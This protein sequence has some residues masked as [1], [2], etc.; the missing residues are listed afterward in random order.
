VLL[1]AVREHQL[2]RLRLDQLRRDL[3]TIDKA[4]SMTPG[5]TIRSWERA[6]V[7][8]FPETTMAV[9]FSTTEKERQ[10][11]QM[12]TGDAFTYTQGSRWNDI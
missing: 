4:I 10:H 12:L 6:I 1:L 3:G 11:T 5:G 8:T 2:D 9:Y 7:L